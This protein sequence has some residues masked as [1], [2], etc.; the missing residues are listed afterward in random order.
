MEKWYLAYKGKTI[1]MTVDFSYKMMERR[2]K[3]CNL[4]QVVKEKYYQ[5]KTLW[6]YPLGTEKGK[7]RHI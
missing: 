4:I 2:R 3:Q 1:W 5:P 7:T 6:K